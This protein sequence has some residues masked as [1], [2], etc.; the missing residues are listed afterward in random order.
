MLTAIYAVDEEPHLPVKKEV[1]DVW[2]SSLG[3]SKAEFEGAVVAKGYLRAVP[4][5]LL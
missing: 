1:G 5:E 2:V 4:I 3:K